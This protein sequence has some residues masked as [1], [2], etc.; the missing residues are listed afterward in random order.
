MS[1][2][3]PTELGALRTTKGY[4]EWGALTGYSKSYDS[5]ETKRRRVREDDPGD[6]A[7]DEQLL[8][9]LDSQEVERFAARQS[10]APRVPHLGPVTRTTPEYVGFNMA[11]LDIEATDLKANFGRMLCL[12][13]ADNLGN[14]VTL[15][16][17]DPEYVGRKRRDDSRLAV[18]ARDYL[19]QFD[20][21]VGWN[22]KMYDIPFID[23][24]LLIAGERPLRKDVMHIDPMWKAGR[25]SLALHSRRLDAVAKTFRLDSQKTPLD[26]ETWQDAAEGE[27]E[28]MDNVVEH[29]E[30][31]TLTL[32]AA[33][34]VLK[35]LIK[36]IHR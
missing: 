25:F 36:T 21:W 31:D 6:D 33:F 28:A 4:H 34:H 15:R 10:V 27:R 9:T 30:A 8:A 11:F 7:A 22:S 5:W 19:E 29:C 35:P 13:V 16:G 32:R 1:K 23:S 24:R 2:W 17:D 18:A 26:F 12:S 20:V 3:T 14:V